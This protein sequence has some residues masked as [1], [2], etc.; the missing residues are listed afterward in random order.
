MKYE[1][2]IYNYIKRYSTLLD[3][4]SKKK[5]EKRKKKEEEEER[6]IVPQRIFHFLRQIYCC[7]VLI[8]IP[9]FSKVQFF[10][11]SN[12]R[13]NYQIVLKLAHDKKRKIG[14]KLGGL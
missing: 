5:K 9:K 7:Y 4:L 13:N 12:Q 6:S 10:S 3:F 11:V 2:F 8:G 14:M 1:I